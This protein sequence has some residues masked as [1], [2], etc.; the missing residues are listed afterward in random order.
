MSNVTQA[1]C[2][3]LQ[4]SIG[5]GDPIGLATTGHIDALRRV[6]VGRV[7]GVFAQADARN[8]E[9][10]SAEEAFGTVMD[11]AV[12][13]LV[14]EDFGDP[15][16]A[17]A[18]HLHSPELATA[19]AEAGFRWFTLDAGPHV[20]RDAEHLGLDELTERLHSQ[21]AA[22]AW[23][24]DFGDQLIELPSGTRIELDELTV[25]RAAVK[26]IPAVAAVFD[27]ADAIRAVSQEYHQPYELEVCLAHTDTP[28]T[29]AEHYMLA[30]RLIKTGNSHHP[31]LGDQVV[32]VSPRFRGMLP[33]SDYTGNP[34]E[35]V[36]ELRDHAAI[37]S[38]LGPYK[39]GLHNGS[40]KLSLYA[41]FARVTDGR[42]HLKTSATSYLEALR[43]V[44]LEDLELF[45]R[46]LI[47]SQNAY[48]GPEDAA[49]LP[50]PATADESD[51]ERDWLGEQLQD[52]ATLTA[53]PEPDPDAP[54]N[55]PPPAPTPA[56][57]HDAPGR[58]ILAATRH[59]VL[60]DPQT[61]Q[62][63]VELL[64]EYPGTHRDLL[65]DHF[66][67]H[68]EALVAGLPDRR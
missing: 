43:A 10:D 2:L 66:A 26:F 28:T 36:A 68:L 9:V 40:D 59:A 1:A 60:S 50:D 45:R 34:D 64:D 51:L 54:R 13:G 25:L 55:A 19:A 67:T 29:L 3:G 41:D 22:Q 39:L 16:G 24:D 18:D 14:E 57:G 7:R 6:G 20:D 15:W 58:R 27:M 42:C 49:A 23:L 48:T 52:Y 21:D 33:A 46:I 44:L 62:A 63:V 8:L 56:F 11:Q 32:C 65:A 30:E 4:P 12:A 38:A 37:A 31:G 35:F 53:P 61:R 17:D 5:F 47:T